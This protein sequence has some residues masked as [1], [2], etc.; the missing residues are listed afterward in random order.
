MVVKT[1]AC[2]FSEN[3]IYPGKGSRVITKESKV[4]LFSTK[5]SKAFWKR[6]TKSQNIRWTITWRRVNKKLKTDE[7]SKRRRRKNKKLVKDIQG[8]NR[9]DI[10]RMREEAPKTSGTAIKNI[11]DRKAK[12]LRG[13]KK[14]TGKKTTR[15]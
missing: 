1:E 12:N 7:E 4:L 2:Y 10:M 9:A 6:K 5:K 11:K 8:L 13:G 14:T 3:K 15:K